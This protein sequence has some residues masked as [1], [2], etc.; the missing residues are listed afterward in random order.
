[1]IGEVTALLRKERRQALRHVGAWRSGLLAPILILVIVAVPLLL[2]FSALPQTA[3]GGLPNVRGIGLLLGGGQPM[4]Q[5]ILP[6]LVL[7]TGLIL[8]TVNMLNAVL[9]ERER[10]TYELLAALPLDQRA[11]VIAKGLTV[12]GVAAGQAAPFVLL[13][14]TLVVLL[15]LADVT[16]ASALLLLLCGALSASVGLSALVGLLSRD[17]RTATNTTGLLSASLFLTSGSLLVAEWLPAKVV[18]VAI[19]LVL[20]GAA[21]FALGFRR[22]VLQRYFS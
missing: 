19:G 13:D 9:S 12:F 20:F 14:G 5:W 22:Q 6:A 1:M 7:V 17:L 21:T 16:Y 8:P 15:G 18:V 4:T 2:V 10:R 3:V 11:V